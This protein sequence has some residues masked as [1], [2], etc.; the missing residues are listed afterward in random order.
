MNSLAGCRYEPHSTA[1]ESAVVVA[2]DL[3]ERNPRARAD[4]ILNDDVG[5]AQEVRM[6]IRSALIGAL[7]IAALSGCGT[8]DHPADTA[9]AA[10]PS[11]P[12][13]QPGNPA[14][15]KSP[16]PDEIAVTCSPEGIAVAAEKVQTRPGGVALR[17]TS[18]LPRGSYLRY[19]S[20]GSGGVS[21]GDPIHP[22]EQTWSLALAP[23]TATLGCDPVNQMG[24][25]KTTT[26]EVTDPGKNWRGTRNLDAAGCVGGGINDWAL[27]FTDHADSAQSAAEAVARDFE[28]WAVKGGHPGPFTTKPLAVG[29]VDA[30]T[31]TW[32]LMA[33][34]V[35][36]ATILVNR[37]KDDYNAGPDASCEGHRESSG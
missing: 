11:D 30:T 37:T 28:S 34:G 16:L 7:A 32:L 12:A 22:G 14:L 6:H 3:R 8:T 29:Y 10:Q 2:P 25:G 19:K 21:G 9:P 13:G 4:V 31:Q 36:Y 20:T 24:E 1:D 27:G 33:S 26:I 5:L 17:I 15:V 23:G 35:P 18:G